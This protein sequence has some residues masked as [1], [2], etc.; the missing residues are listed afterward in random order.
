M[1]INHKRLFT[2]LLIV[3]LVQLSCDTTEF[4]D[5]GSERQ[6]D[7]DDCEERGG[8]WH[9]YPVAYCELPPDSITPTPTTQETTDAYAEGCDAYESLTI[10][11]FITEE[12]QYDTW[13]SCQYYL[14]VTNSN[15]M[16]S[17]WLWVHD[18]HVTETGIDRD[19]WNSWKIEAGATEERSY[20]G[21]FQDNGSFGHSY[22]SE[23]T[24]ILAIP[25]C[26]DM[27]DK[28]S[29]ITLARPLQWFCGP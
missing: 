13:R 23:I 11:V 20:S 12:A 3:M 4:Y 7:R 16:Q 28:T 29:A 27:R 5:D 19:E 6:K 1:A 18:I 21:D 22:A 24:A 10:E 17:A 8:I 15:T 14:R 9:D 2:V 26:N 25:E